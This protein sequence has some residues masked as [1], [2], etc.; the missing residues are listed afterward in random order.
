MRGLVEWSNLM[1][2]YAIATIL[3][4]GLTVPAF[5]A[6]P[7]TASQEKRDVTPG[8]SF[9]AKDHWAVDDTVGNCSVIDAKPS[10]YDTSGLKVLGDKSGYPSLSAAQKEIKSDKSVCKGYVLRG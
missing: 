4:V 10:S 3:L 1:K 2:Q 7:S 8:F 9:V 5:A 6:R